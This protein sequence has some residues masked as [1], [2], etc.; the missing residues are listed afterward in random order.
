MSCIR[1]LKFALTAVFF[2]FFFKFALPGKRRALSI[3]KFVGE[4]CLEMC[5][6]Q[7]IVGL[8]AI[9][10]NETESNT[11]ILTFLYLERNR[12]VIKIIPG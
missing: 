6:S 10:S 8:K 1:I 3:Y 5:V 2:C 12:S 9:P 11:K 4:G 7:E